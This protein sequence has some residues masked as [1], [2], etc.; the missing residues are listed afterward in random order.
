MLVV[1][2][3]S[4]VEECFSKNDIIFADRPRFTISTLASSSYGDH[5]RNLRHIITLEVLSSN[6]L[7]MTTGIR[8]DEIKNLLRKL[9]HISADGLTKVELRPLF[10]ELT[11]NIAIRMITGKRYYGSD[12][13]GIEQAR[14]FR[15]LIEEM[16]TYG[17]AAYPGDF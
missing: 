15:E 3:A 13:A 11:F 14:Q 4:A 1:S 8:K 2:S 9:Y 16:F 17:G 10:S 7:N 6:H 12:V 5:W